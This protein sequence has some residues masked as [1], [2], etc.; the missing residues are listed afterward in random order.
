MS[1]LKLIRKK[2]I[3]SMLSKLRE[4][5]LTE[6]KRCKRISPNVFL[7]LVL[8][9]CFFAGGMRFSEQEFDASKI[10]PSPDRHE[11]A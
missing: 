1:K 3:G 5:S 10:N 11:F 7:V 9:L 6:A 4:W 8:G 2:V